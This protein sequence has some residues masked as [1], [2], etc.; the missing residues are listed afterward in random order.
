MHTAEGRRILF[1]VESLMIISSNDL[2]K[3][4][5]GDSNL[6]KCYIL[7]DLLKASSQKKIF[8]RFFFKKQI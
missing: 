8:F 2:K 4:K 7:N 1:I 6:F 5:I 3:K